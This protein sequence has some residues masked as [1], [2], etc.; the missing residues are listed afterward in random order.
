MARPREVVRRQLLTSIAYRERGGDMDRRHALASI[1]SWA[2]APGVL[3]GRYRLF[4]GV[5]DEY[6]ARAIKLVEE[7]VVIDMLNQFRFADFSEKPPRSEKWL[8]VPR[9]FAREEYELYRTSGIRAL[10]LGHG[11]SSYE[12]AVKWFADWNGF[13]AAYDEW[14]L[15]IDDVSDLER[16]RRTGR[17]GI[18]L[19]FQNSD[20]FRTPDDVE[21]FFGLGQRVSQLTYN[22]QNR[23]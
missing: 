2:V 18:M 19:T 23:I 4:Q 16:A 8:R 14:L 12:P 22:F 3:R 6:S 20:H 13:L 17:L 21:T 1:A 10:A 7:T 15:R 11:A 9:S 5:D